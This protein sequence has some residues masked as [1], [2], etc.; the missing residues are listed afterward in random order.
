MSKE[1][2][3]KRISFNKISLFKI[4]FSD[5][6]KIKV[7]R[8][9]DIFQFIHFKGMILG[10]K[11]HFHHLCGNHFGHCSMT[12]FVQSGA[13]ICDGIRIGTVLKNKFAL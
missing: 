2:S 12:I 4:S 5:G 6:N 7:L 9:D 1:F 3:G 8:N 10:N 11:T 13:Q